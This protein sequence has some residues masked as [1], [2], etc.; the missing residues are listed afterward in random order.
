MEVMRLPAAMAPF[1]LA[2][3]EGVPGIEEESDLIVHWSKGTETWRE[4]T[5]AF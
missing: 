3:L 1:W 4:T 2:G 5:E